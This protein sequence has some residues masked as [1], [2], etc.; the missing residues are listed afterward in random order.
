MIEDL[1]YNLEERKNELKKGEQDRMENI[2]QT[3]L[4]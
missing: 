2:S 1:T 4:L 3:V